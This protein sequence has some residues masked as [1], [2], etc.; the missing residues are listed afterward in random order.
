MVLSLKLAWATKETEIFCS[1]ICL[2]II[3]ASAALTI[4][5]I[6]FLGPIASARVARI[7]NKFVL[8]PT[9]DEMLE[10]ELD[11][12]VAGTKKGVLMVESEAKELSEDIML[13]AVEFGKKSYMEVLDLIIDLAKETARFP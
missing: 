11:L 7:K 1:I 2:V 10:S 4:S 13:E 9:N 6:P 12:V 3:A 5:G 8:N